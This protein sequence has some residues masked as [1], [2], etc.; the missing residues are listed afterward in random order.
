MFGEFD[1]IETAY[2]QSFFWQNQ[3]NVVF[4]TTNQ[5]Q[6]KKKNASRPQKFII[7]TQR[8]SEW[9]KKLIKKLKRATHSLLETTRGTASFNI[10][11]SN[12]IQNSVLPLKMQNRSLSWMVCKTFMTIFKRNVFLVQWFGKFEQEFIGNPPCGNNLMGLCPQQGHQENLDQGLGA[13]L[14]TG[15]A[16]LKVNATEFSFCQPEL[17]CNDAPDPVTKFWAII[18]ESASAFMLGGEHDANHYDLITMTMWNMMMMTTFCH[19]NWHSH[20]C[21]CQNFFY[22]EKFIRTDK[23]LIDGDANSI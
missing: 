6:K 20:H 8:F 5:K 7:I 12:K 1:L 17:E 22:A 3:E 15:G 23:D 4:G 13:C 16:G 11:E 14:F 21:N 19:W 10:A 9:K 2:S 18:K